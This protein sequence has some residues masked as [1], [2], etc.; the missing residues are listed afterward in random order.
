MNKYFPLY[1]VVT[2]FVRDVIT[3]SINRCL[4][5]EMLNENILN[6]QQSYYRITLSISLTIVLYAKR[7]NMESVSMLSRKFVD[8]EKVIRME[9]IQPENGLVVR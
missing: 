9:V 2:G 5:N 6:S 1:I 8:T 4:Q 3:N 7:Q